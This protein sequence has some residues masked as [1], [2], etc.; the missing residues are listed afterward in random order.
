MLAMC[1]TTD[2]QGRPV[3]VTAHQENCLRLLEL[4]SFADRGTINEQ[5]DVRAVGWAPGGL[6]IAGSKFGDV[7]I[8]RWKQPTM[9]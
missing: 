3:L 6:I 5:K 7:R 1:G 2:G 8:W 4:P 9:Q